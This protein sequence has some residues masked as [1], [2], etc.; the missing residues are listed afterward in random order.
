MI[1]RLRYYTCIE[2]EIH[3][4]KYKVPT[5][6]LRDVFLRLSDLGPITWP[7]VNVIDERLLEV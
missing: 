5:C 6:R 1:V 3:R 4:Q 7:V 2:E